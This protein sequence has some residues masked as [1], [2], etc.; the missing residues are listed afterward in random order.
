MSL[1]A[2][3]RKYTFTVLNIED[4]V[5]MQHDNQRTC[6]L[7]DDEMTH[8]VSAASAQRRNWYTGTDRSRITKRK[9]LCRRPR[10]HVQKN[11]SKDFPSTLKCISR[12]INLPIWVLPSAT[13]TSDSPATGNGLD[14]GGHAPHASTRA[15]LP[16]AKSK[17]QVRIAPTRI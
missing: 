16:S 7:L 12:S 9:S 6:C 11:R 2:R 8:F 4:I 15:I 14:A 10:F 3:A 17:L 5:G 1:K 13:C